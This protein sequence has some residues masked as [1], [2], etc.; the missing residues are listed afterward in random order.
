MSNPIKNAEKTVLVEKNMFYKSVIGNNLMMTSYF[1]CLLECTECYSIFLVRRHF[2]KVFFRDGHDKLALTLNLLFTAFSRYFC[3][4]I[5]PRSLLSCRFFH[6][7]SLQLVCDNV[8]FTFWPDV[9]LMW[10]LSETL[11]CLIEET[12]DRAPISVRA[13]GSWGLPTR[14]PPSQIFGNSDFWGSKRNFGK[15]NFYQSFHVSFRLSFS[16]R[17]I[18]FIFRFK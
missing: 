11:M 15:A 12:G 9:W 5:F 8:A 3:T 2:S 14:P 4:L 16:L 13:G 7:Y 10:N 18:F 17:D 1:S 6:T